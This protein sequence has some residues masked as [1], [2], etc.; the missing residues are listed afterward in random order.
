M[1]RDIKK[2]SPTFPR[3][4]ISWANLES[5]NMPCRRALPITG[6]KAK[7]KQIAS[8]QIGGVLVTVVMTN[9]L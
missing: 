7:R 8:L 4:C 1:F 3:L 2:F 9:R 6:T 5:A